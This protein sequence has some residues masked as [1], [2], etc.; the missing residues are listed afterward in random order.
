VSLFEQVRVVLAGRYA[1]ER[2]LG[3]GGMAVVFFAQDLKQHRPVAIKVLRPELAA[4]IGAERFLREIEIAARLTHPHILPL[5]DSGEADGLLFYVT[6]YIE[7]ESL[8]D[9][10]TRERQLPVEDAV[11]IT[12]QVASALSHAHSHDVVHR[13]IKPENILLAGDE[14]VVADFGIARA[15]TAAGGEKLTATGIAVGTPAYMSPEQ[16][17]AEPTLDGRSDVYSLG[18]VLYEMLAGEPPYTGPSAQAMLARRLTDPVPPLRTVR[19]TVP[20]A[21][22]Q[23]IEKALAR[24]PADR[25]PT[26]IQFAEALRQTATP[27]GTPA[28]GARR[29]VAR[30]I[31]GALAVLIVAVLTRLFWPSPNQRSLDP[32]LI[33]VAPFDVRGASLASWSE[34]LVE[35]LSRSLDGA[36][37]LQTVSPSLFLRRW[38]GRADPAAARDLGRR[39]G[40]GLVV[41]GSLV[42]GGRDSIRLRATLLDVA[43]GR[44]LAEVDVPGDTLAMDRAADSL[45]VTL[46]RGLGRARPVGAVRN[47]PFSGA[48]LPA[49]KAFLQGEHFYRRSQYDSALANHARAIALDSSFALAN[50]RISLE[51]GWHPPTGG[52]FEPPETYAFRAAALNH[53]LAPRDSMLIAADSLSNALNYS[54]VTESTTY[55][56]RHRLHA[57]LEETAQRFPGD[58]EV[59]MAL[60]EARSH[61][62]DPV[63]TPPEVLPAFDK[64]IALDSGFT[65][66]YEHVLNLA[67]YIGGA[68][69]ARRYAPAI[70]TST[71]D[72]ASLRLAAMLLDPARS[73]SSD[74]ND[75]I[76]TIGVGPLWRAGLE[77]LGVW[78]D[79]A[80]TVIRL[81]RA[82][83]VGRRSLAGVPGWVGDTLMWPHYLATVLLY[84]GH[85]REAYQVYRPLL[86]HPSNAP[87]AWFANPFRDLALV[88]AVPA[89]TVTA[90]IARS[91]QSEVLSSPRWF[92]WWYTRRDTAALA[93]VVDHADRFAPRT[94]SPGDKVRAL[95]LRSA[96][97]GYLAL[98]RGDSATAIR[99]LQAVP[100]SVIT[101]D[102]RN[103]F[104][105][106]KLTLAELL[107]AR[108]DDRGAGEIIDRWLWADLGPFLI[109]ARLERAR[110]AE[111]AGD[112]DKAIQWYQFVVDVWRHADPELQSYVI[113]AR[114][115]LRRLGGEPRR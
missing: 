24:V 7:G 108:R 110:I 55:L 73:Q 42:Q 105:F 70:L 21:V 44:A 112:R 59:W 18:C 86:T 9:R 23:A 78:A 8:R 53:G 80:E 46:L 109:L 49:I 89:E 111:R 67:M 10:L 37:E 4:A 38:S 3:H 1:V 75:F 14:V 84:R 13:D 101:V 5:Y 25:Y 28:V 29:S 100:D 69:L 98:A 81:L 56:L 57:I 19:Q 32:D 17:M 113:E 107:E 60:G 92:R 50:W 114:E 77:H 39:T 61:Q 6:P 52:G 35:Y 15:I 76:D 71:T 62:A 36:G 74:V 12:R 82:V 22:E 30:R 96:A 91:S 20:P 31:A 47:A 106:E 58:P 94:A 33:A 34:G 97:A 54:D 41:F 104:L 95:A 115:G 90:V 68:D 87:W 72:D 79:S 102:F 11:E 43:A 2:E 26:A 27:P 40:A 51:L 83:P 16:A 99:D 66:A 85:A 103:P 88:G 63:W 64:A 65:P 93:R 48:S 45:A